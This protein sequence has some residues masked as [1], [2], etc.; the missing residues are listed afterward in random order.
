M[1][2]RFI[3][4]RTGKPTRILASAAAALLLAL[5]AA[6][7]PQV[8]AGTPVP[9]AA[10]D[11]ADSANYR[12]AAT[13]IDPDRLFDAKALAISQGG[14]DLYVGSA[15]GLIVFSRDTAT[16]DLHFIE[17]HALGDVRA[18][19]VSPDSGRVYAA[20]YWDNSISVYARDPATHTL[21]QI[22]IVKDG[23]GGVTGLV[24]PGALAMSPGGT[25]IH[26]AG[27]WADALVQCNVATGL[28]TFLDVQSDDALGTRGLAAIGAT[29]VAP[30][31]GQLYVA[32]TSPGT[33][34]TWQRD[35]ATGMLT[36]VATI[37]DGAPGIAGLR[38]PTVWNACRDAAVGGRSWNDRPRR[39]AAPSN[40]STA[41][42]ARPRCG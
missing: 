30:D 11:A 40:W 20:A 39:C 31:G 25:F 42:P 32:S 18:L 26:V 8:Q 21:T 19:A 36:F 28:L 37:R 24:G 35:P 38:L 6:A 12:V 29:I 27:E 4:Y 23:S 9:A 2:K 7:A 15:N 14:L 17:S 33:L 16:G 10:L 1:S 34:S 13:L 3:F 41:S 22:Q 5:L